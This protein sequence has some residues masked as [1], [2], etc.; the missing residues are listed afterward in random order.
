MTHM[1]EPPVAHEV[2]QRILVA[3]D[4]SPNSLAALDAAATLAARLETEL[5]GLFIEDVDLLKAAALPFTR[6]V[7][8]LSRE[9]VPLELEDVE[10]E[11]RTQVG[12]IRRRLAQLEQEQRLRWEL[13]VERGRPAVALAEVAQRGDL[14]A[15][16]VPSGTQAGH[17][18]TEPET[19]QESMAHDYAL[20]LIVE[21]LS[22][23]APIAVVYDRTEAAGA[24]LVTGAALAERQHLPLLV[25]V[26]A[27]TADEA[28]S[29]RR[30]ALSLLPH[31]TR[32]SFQLIIPG[33]GERLIEAL[34]RARPQICVCN[35][36]DGESG[37]SPAAL[38]RASGCSI[39]DCR[40]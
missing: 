25:L 12:A 2:F 40:S 37:F 31:L 13:R 7:S 27:R 8:L 1:P 34:R 22:S 23:T 29:L 6:Q 17:I 15:M 21:K 14:V 10:A 28:E 18:S 32:L 35:F 4:L 24:A 5:V 11:F 20:L 26:L 33:S 19:A 16:K 30:Q 9:A 3:L 36:T 38:A 39:L